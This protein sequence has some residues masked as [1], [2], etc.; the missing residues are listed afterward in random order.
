MTESA[1]YSPV[2]DPDAFVGFGFAAAALITVLYRI[3][4]VLADERTAGDASGEILGK[5]LRSRSRW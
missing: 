3:V 2:D 5:L 4:N 1:L